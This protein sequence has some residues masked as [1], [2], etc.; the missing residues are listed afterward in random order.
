MADLVSGDIEVQ[1]SGDP[2]SKCGGWITFPFIIDLDHVNGEPGSIL[3]QSPSDLQLGILYVVLA[4]VTTGTAGTRVALASAGANQYEKPKD[5]GTF[6]NCYFLMVNTGAIISA[7]EIVYTQDNASWKLGF[8]LC[9]AANLISFV[10][11][12]S[13]KRLYKHKKPMGSPFT[14]L[15]R[16]SRF[17]SEKKG[18]YLI[19]KRRLL[20][21]WA[22]TKEQEFCCSALQELQTEGESGD[23]TNSKWRLCS[24]QEV[25][26]FKAVLRLLPLWLSII[27]VSIPI[28]VQSSLMVLQ[29]L[30]MDR[31][32]S[33]HLK[34]SAGSI[35]VIAIIFSCIF[36]LM[37]NWL[38]YPMYH[39]LTNKVMTP[40]QK[41]GM[42]HVF[43]ILSMAISAVVE[44]KRLKTV[45]NEHLMSVLWLFPP[46]VIL[47]ISEA[48]QL[49]AHIELFYGEFP[50]SLRNTATSL[51]SLV[52]GIT[53]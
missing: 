44:S 31:V 15:V 34:V 7:T 51:T 36:I 45:Q 29:A 52:I 8:G 33:P 37:N 40:L 47:G 9:A 13:R 42:G 48:F 26:D 38:F 24:V 30:V 46:F 50:E 11:F 6:F 2:S 49:P 32:F 41:I 10:L 23:T 14:S 12:I 43:T 18:C 39:K 21:P 4:L 3:C 53:F 27:F 16:V 17:Y 28:A 25:E 20:P 35:Q 1:H 22:R 5:Q 19:Q